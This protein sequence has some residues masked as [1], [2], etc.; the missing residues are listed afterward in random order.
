[1]AVKK[2]D[3]EKSFKYF[4]KDKEYY[5][6]RD[7]HVNTYARFYDKNYEEVERRISKFKYVTGFL[8][9]EDD[10]GKK[11]ILHSWIEKDGFV[12]D[13]TPFA[14]LY[15]FVKEDF[16][17]DNL[18][19]LKKLTINKS[20]YVSLTALSDIEFTKKCKEIAS[21]CEDVG[22]QYIGA[23]ED[24][25]MKI[26]ESI[27]SNEKLIMRQRELGYEFMTGDYTYFIH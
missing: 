2:I 16:S 7:C 17:D 21:N 24:F 6:P 23:I 18:Q 22:S 11:C 9:I 27:S 8:D 15:S 14:N 19:E 4:W 3:F 25:I 1:M 26:V 13:V 20:K 10:D 5:Q 12:I